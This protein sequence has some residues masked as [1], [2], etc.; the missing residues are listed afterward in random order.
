MGIATWPSVNRQREKKHPESPSKE[1]PEKTKK[2]INWHQQNRG[3]S[4][5][6]QRSTTGIVQQTPNLIKSQSDFSLFR[7]EWV[8]YNKSNR[9]E[10]AGGI[11]FSFQAFARP[12]GLG[13][14]SPWIRRHGRGWLSSSV[15]L[16]AA[17]GNAETTGNKTGDFL[18]VGLDWFFFEVGLSVKGPT[19]R[20]FR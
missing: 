3:A 9:G 10:F 13:G 1:A 17:R 6:H 20:K 12:P 16:G 8:W 11:C 5:G 19:R 2:L 18:Q 15:D 7:A 4:E 14:Q